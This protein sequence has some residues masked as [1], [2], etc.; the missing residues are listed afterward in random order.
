MR[1]HLASP[2]AMN[3]SITTWAPLAKSPNWPSQMSRVF[4]SVVEKPYS[5][6]ITA[7]SL[8]SESITVAC[9]GVSTSWRSGR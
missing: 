2:E 3:W 6:A 9:S 8:S 1:P 7:S 5:N 4:G